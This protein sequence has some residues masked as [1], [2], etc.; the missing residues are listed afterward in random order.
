ME[1]AGMEILKS[2]HSHP[3]T[4]GAE[5]KLL[6]FSDFKK[7][8]GDKKVLCAINHLNEI[9]LQVIVGNYRYIH[10]IKK[11]TTLYIKLYKEIFN[12]RIPYNLW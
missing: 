1:I 7:I 2:T 5:Y 12:N 10:P 3:S 6:S 4:F 8:A 9:I 11:G